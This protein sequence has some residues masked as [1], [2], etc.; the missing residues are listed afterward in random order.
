MDPRH[1]AWDDKLREARGAMTTSND[2]PTLE[3]ELLAEI[4]GAADLGAIE[5]VRVG[6]IGKKGRVSELTNLKLGGVVG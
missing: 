5:A 2:L 1:E 3:T 6:A 4:A